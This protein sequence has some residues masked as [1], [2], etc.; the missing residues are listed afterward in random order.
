[1]A[2]MVIDN[3]EIAPAKA[4]AALPR[5]ARRRAPAYLRDPFLWAAV[6][7]LAAIILLAA[8]AP[9]MYPGDPL[10]MVDAPLLWP[11]DNWAHPLGTDQLGRDVAAGIAHGARVSLLVGCFAALIG[12]V[13]GTAI[14]ATAGYF[15][16]VI[17]NVLVRITELFQT[18]PTILLVIVIIAI[19]DPSVPLI[20]FA[21]GVASWPMIAR[22]ARAQFM[23]LREAD[24]VMA[25]RGLGYGTTR[26]I[27]G[28][29]LPNALPTLVVATSVLVANGILAEAGLS[30]LN[31]G[32]PNQV[33]WGSLIGNGRSMLRSEWYLSAL[34]G[35]AIVLTVLSV[36]IIGDRLT[37]ILNP[38]SGSR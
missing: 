13:I 24:F 38:R 12:L 10:D 6:I 31:L 19:G 36:N 1:M 26:I 14:G 3:M 20:V 5:A 23:A 28:E 9:L 37:D 30:F 27:L 32:D 21:I 16:G 25:A 17:D 8:A 22:L 15:G 18:I 35:L 7:V 11:G 33:S 2:N 29:I 4:D 34:P